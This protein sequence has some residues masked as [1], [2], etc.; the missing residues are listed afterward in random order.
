M[1]KAIIGVCVGL[2]IGTTG[3]ALAA[4]TE[5]FQA[6]AAKFNFVV[7]GQQ[8]E[9]KNSPVT[10][11]GKSYLPV[12]DVADMLGYDVKYANKTVTFTSKESKEAT[13]TTPATD[14]DKKEPANEPAPLKNEYKLGETVEFPNAKIKINNVSYTTKNEKITQHISEGQRYAVVELD[15]YITPNEEYPD[16]PYGPNSFIEK[17]NLTNNTST[18]GISLIDGE[19]I[20]TG[21]WQSVKAITNSLVPKDVVLESLTLTSPGQSYNGKNPIVTID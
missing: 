17:I 11:N 2:L 13:P 10:I 3:T 4:Q 5:T 12:V 15:I 14:T 6:I 20:K 8:K 16:L 7:D 18:S 9:A 21:K 1:K 19:T